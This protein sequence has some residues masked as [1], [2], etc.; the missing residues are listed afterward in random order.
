V[1]NHRRRLA[2]Q[3]VGR[4]EVQG[5]Q[6]DKHLIRSLARALTRNDE[7]ARRLRD[8]VSRSVAGEEPSRGGV[9]AALR[10]SPLVGSDIDLGREPH[11]GRD[12]DL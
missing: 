3:G 9:L 1:E 4:F 6:T 2:E 11:P 5:L 10:A 8:Q 12:V 7:Q